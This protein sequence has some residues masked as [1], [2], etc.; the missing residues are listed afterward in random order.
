MRDRGSRCLPPG[1]TVRRILRQD[2]G[3]HPYKMAVVQ[4]LNEADYPQRAGLD[5]AML[6]LLTDE[7]D[8]ILIRSD[9]AHFHLNGTVNRQN[10]RY[11]APDN[12]N[13]LHERPL[14]SPRVTVWCGI[15]KCGVIGPYFF[16]ENGMT[17]TSDLYVNM[18]NN[19]F[20][21]ELRRRRINRRHV[22]FQQEGG[23]AHTA[24]ALMAAVRHQTISRFGDLH[25]PPR[26][27]D[28]S[29]CDFFLW[30]YLK[31][32]VYA[33]KPRS[34]PQLYKAIRQNIAQIDEGLLERVQT[35]FRD[36]LRVCV[37]NYGHDLSVIIFCT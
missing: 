17:V 29:M 34:L 30:S 18:I 4:E 5:E 2:L 13:I 1:T 12:P 11:W 26:S 9:E 22:W 6:Q 14:H 24:R 20:K 8:V 27:P 19:F 7:P 33:T 31:S 15:G 21:N 35:N 36:R 28:L 3:L 16:E 32:R 23:T 10:F 25:W 37:R